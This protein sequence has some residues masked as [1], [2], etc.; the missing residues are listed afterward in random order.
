MKYTYVLA[1]AALISAGSMY[2]QNGSAGQ[3]AMDTVFLPFQA[4][5]K[6]PQKFMPHRQQMNNQP[7]GKMMSAEQACEKGG[8]MRQG[9]SFEQCVQRYNEEMKNSPAYHAPQE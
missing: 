9:E 5:K 7:M 6:M 2:A 3:T 4:A 8:Y 1:L